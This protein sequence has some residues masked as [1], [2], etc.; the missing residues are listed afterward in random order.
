MV[1]AMRKISKTLLL[2]GGIGLAGGAV[3]VLGLHGCASA[4]KPPQAEISS[5]PVNNF[6]FPLGFSTQKMDPS[7]DPSKDF[8]RYAAG[9]WI[10]AAKIPA[11]TVRIS[12]VDVQVKV[13]EQQQLALLDEAAH[14]SLTA[15]KG[16]PSQQ[17]GDF[18]AAGM[19]EKRLSELGVKPLQPELD[20]IAKINDKKSLIEELVRLYLLTNDQLLLGLQVGTDPSDRTRNIVY[21][22][23]GDLPM[24]IDNYLKPEGKAIRDAHVKQITDS[25]VIAGST[26]EAAAAVAAKVL[27]MDIRVA[28]KKL[29]P[30]ELRDPAKRFIRMRYADMKA[31]LSNVD[32]DTLFRSQGMPTSGEVIVVQVG[33]LLERNAILGE[34][35]L[36]D[37]KAYLSWELLLRS[38]VYLTP[39]FLGPQKTFTQALYGKIEIPPRNRLVAA[40]VPT[41]LGHPLGQV[42]VAKHFNVDTKREVEDLIQRVRTEFRERLQKNTWLEPRTRAEAL[43]KLDAAKIDVGY[44]ATWI[45][46]SGVDIRRDDYLG[47]VQRINE[48]LARRD[49][50]KF[51]KPVVEDGFAM[52]GNTLPTDINAAY[53]PSRNGIEIPAAFLQPPFF[54]PKADPASNYCALGAV[55]GHEITHGFDSQ[56]RQ[57]DEKGNVRNW[58]TDADAQRFVTEANKLVGQADAVEVLPGLHINGQLAVGENLADVGGVSLG[59]AAL[60]K[61]LREHPEQNRS[62]DGLSQDQRCFLAWAQVWADKGNEGWLKQTVPT[63]P[64][65]PGVYR[66]IAPAQHEQTFYEAFGIRSGDPTWLPEQ[67]RVSLW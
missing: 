43:K 48:F 61:Y 16:S 52:A 19:D 37:T 9:R 56:G 33:A 27:A 21:I 36:E 38:S 59:H 63:D 26:P 55:I 58:W 40:T 25:L 14:A 53:Q 57:Y 29:T 22:G 13:V 6:G 41:K 7:A 5:T 34:L 39:A 11:D 44:P 62:I 54:D 18:Y 31:L 47:N 23:E 67:N 32:I 51:G 49:L 20:R 66:M 35:P 60:K 30:V 10:D 8:R 24:G 50:A 2:I 65:P 42:Y 45:D 4:P 1:K 46:Y 17:V 3:G 28:A 12:G 15:H 64:H